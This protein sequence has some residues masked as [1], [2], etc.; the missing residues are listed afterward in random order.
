[1]NVAATEKLRGAK[2]RGVSA[3]GR[4]YAADLKAWVAGIATGY[5][6]AAALLFGGVL[7]VFAAVAVGGTALFHFL[8]LRYGANTAFA[9]LGGGLLALGAILLL[10]GWAMIGRQAPPLPRPD[11]QLRAAKQ[12]LMGS[13]ISRAVVALH[14]NEAAKPDATTQMLIGAA[15]ILA[16]GWIAASRLGGSTATEKSVRRV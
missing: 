13:T 8:E 5:G 16:V 6:I 4:S 7:A 10:A 14:G 3:L 12:M 11:R 9:A 2:P 15:A 1:M